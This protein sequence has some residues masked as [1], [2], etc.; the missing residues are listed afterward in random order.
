MSRLYQAVRT[1]RRAL[2]RWGDRHINMQLYN[3]VYGLPTYRQH[4]FFNAGYLPILPRFQDVAGLESEPLQANLY[5]FA[6]RELVGD[7]DHRP[8]TILEV[9]C[10]RGGGLSYLAALF[11]D[12]AITGID[13]NR[14]AIRDARRRL[15]S[16]PRITIRRGDGSATGLPAASFDFVVSV[17]TMT[18]IGIPTFLKEVARVT[19][20]GGLIAATGGVTGHA[21]D[22]MRLFIAHSAADAGLTFLTYV[23]MTQNAFD[24]LEHDVARREAL[25]ARLPRVMQGY[26]R[27]WSDLPGTMRYDNYKIGQRVDF[28]TLLRR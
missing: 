17:G 13:A 22:V 14:F 18:Y 26:A 27:E 6:A 25:V 8:K 23:D 21:S 5:E 12:A 7:P 20:P 3:F 28:G 11:P 10:G 19:R 4:L 2:G 15:A 16:N 1:V 24:A 9:G